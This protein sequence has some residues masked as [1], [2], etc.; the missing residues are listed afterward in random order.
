[1]NFEAACDEEDDLKLRLFT[2]DSTGQIVR[3]TLEGF[4]E[5]QTVTSFSREAQTRFRM[6]R[7]RF[8]KVLVLVDARTFPVQSTKV[9][10][11]FDLAEAAMA[12]LRDRMAIVA[13]SALSKMQAQRALR[14]SAA[15]FFSAVEQAERWLLEGV[16]ESRG[17]R[18][19][20]RG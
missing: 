7:Q 8:G 19:R 2:F 1:M 5:V 13:S 14:G 3:L 6:A 17:I 10:I 18:G 15:A 4:W 11:A 16:G 12:P 9:A 20:S